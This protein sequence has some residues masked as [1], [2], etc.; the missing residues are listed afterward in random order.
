MSAIAQLGY[1]GFEVSDLAS[2][3]RFAT[4]VLGLVVVERSADG[5]F[6]LRMDGHRQRLWIAPGPADDLLVVGWELASAAALDALTTRLRE[7]HLDVVEG[8]R[9]EITNR[10]VERLVKLRDPDGLP[11]ELYCGPALATTPFQSP[12]VRAGF[13]ADALGLGHLVVS[14]KDSD[15]SKA[16]YCDLLDFR[17]SDRIVADVHGFKADLSFFHTNGR[18]HSL[19]FGGPQ[20]KRLHHFMIEARTMD[21][22]GLAFDRALRGGIRIMQTLGRHP[23]DRMFSFYGRTPSGFQFEFGWGGREVD[24]ATWEPRTYDAISEWGHHPPQFLAPGK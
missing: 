1:L 15:A 9:D 12:I 7:R 6:A 14:S 19:A 20:R 3:E 5:A 17:F 16:F 23:N 24:D 4:Q 18:H 13:V 22:V 8:T 10:G 21:E 2:W 11:V